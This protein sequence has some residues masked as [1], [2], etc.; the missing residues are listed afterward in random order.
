MSIVESPA[1]IVVPPL[2]VIPGEGLTVTVATAESEHPLVSVTVTV[3]VVVTEGETV[4]PAAVPPE[5]QA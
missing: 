2:I 3:Y 4:S 5:L 1:Q